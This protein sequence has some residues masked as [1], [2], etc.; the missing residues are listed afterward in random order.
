MVSEMVQLLATVEQTLATRRHLL[1]SGDLAQLGGPNEPH[2]PESMEALPLIPSCRLKVQHNA[3]IGVFDCT[4]LQSEITVPN[5]K[6]S[7]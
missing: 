5:S 6:L 7:S 1:A 2:K 4:A 3:T